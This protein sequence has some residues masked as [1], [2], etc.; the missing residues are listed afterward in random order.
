[1]NK[2]VERNGVLEVDPHRGPVA[3]PPL[4]GRPQWERRLSRFSSC[5]ASRA[6]WAT[7]SSV[8]AGPPGPGSAAKEIRRRGGPSPLPAGP[9]AT[10]HVL[11]WPS[12]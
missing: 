2:H 3:L 1:M 9:L 10:A 11:P 4:P 6:S 5:R 8:V 7:R 12:L